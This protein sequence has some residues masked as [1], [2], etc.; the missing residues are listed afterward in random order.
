MRDNFLQHLIQYDNHPRPNIQ[1]YLTFG[2]A[3]IYF[4]RDRIVQI[5]LN[6]I[7]L[8]L[9]DFWL[10]GEVDILSGLKA[11]RFPSINQTD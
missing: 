4:P 10:N 1:R 8:N 9:V 11:R 5:A 7:S 2:M 6:R 3:A